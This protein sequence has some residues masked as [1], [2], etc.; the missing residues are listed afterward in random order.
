MIFLKNLLTLLGLRRVKFRSPSEALR[1]LI[2]AER[3]E[4]AKKARR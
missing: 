2:E 1:Y 4:Q 3:R